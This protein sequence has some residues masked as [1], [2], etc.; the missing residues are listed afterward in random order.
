MFRI[1][2]VIKMRD[3]NHNPYEPEVQAQHD[4]NDQRSEDNVMKTGT[5]TVGI[6]VD[7]G[8]AIATDRRASLGGRFVAS[9]DVVKVQQVHPTGAVTLVGSVGGAQAF[10][11]QLE[12]EVSLYRSRRGEDMSIE[13][14]SQL[15]KNFARSGP[16]FRINPIVAGVDDTG[17]HVYTVDPA[18]GIMEEDYTV[19]GSG[20][21]VAYG[22]LE[23]GYEEGL[24]LDGA[25]RVAAEAVQ[26]AAERDSG[27]GNGLALA[28]IDE[29]DVEIDTYPDYE[30][31]DDL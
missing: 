18:G 12:A 7:G 24:D 17:S 26:A 13:A 19:N 28:R 2:Q 21:Q 25:T 30:V 15:A 14:L 1:I 27:S 9:K 3:I 4:Q 31:V 11:E 8:V 23:T 29:S 22:T 6:A 10:T 20:M 16:F 5:T